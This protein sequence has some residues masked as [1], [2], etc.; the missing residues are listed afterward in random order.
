MPRAQGLVSAPPYKEQ[1][2]DSPRIAIETVTAVSSDAVRYYEGAYRFPT[3]CDAAVEVV[4]EIRKVTPC[5][6]AAP[7][8]DNGLLGQPNPFNCHLSAPALALTQQTEAP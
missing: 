1:C 2:P 8:F 6:W 4:C 3:A 5:N 7:Y